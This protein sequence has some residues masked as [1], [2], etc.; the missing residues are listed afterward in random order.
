MQTNKQTNKIKNN[1]IYKGYFKSKATT[2][3]NTKNQQDFATCYKISAFNTN[4]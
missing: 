1:K 2:Q 4:K 3:K